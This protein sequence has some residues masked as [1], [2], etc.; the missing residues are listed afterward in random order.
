MPRKNNT[1]VVHDTEYEMNAA[2]LAGAQA[3]RDNVPNS[4]NPYRHLS[5]SHDFWD[6]G[7]VNESADEHF[8]FGRDVLTAPRDGSR[9]EMDPQVPRD[10]GADVNSDWAYAERKRL[11]AKAA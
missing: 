10:N 7:H 9:F 5:Q 3:F 4:C 2:Y 8:R 1:L 11:L 6:Y